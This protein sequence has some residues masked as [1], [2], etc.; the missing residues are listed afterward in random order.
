MG[1]WAGL[2][3]TAGAGTQPCGGARRGSLEGRPPFLWVD[4]LFLH[5]K[6]LVS[7]AQERGSEGALHAEPAVP[8]P[9]RLR[10]IRVDAL[11]TLRAQLN[12]ALAAQEGGKLSLN[13]FVIKVGERPGLSTQGLGQAGVVKEEKRDLVRHSLN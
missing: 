3:A 8:C 10:S 4:S 6:Q 7:R 11:S 12:E 5:R 9:V 1:G 2:G 13:D